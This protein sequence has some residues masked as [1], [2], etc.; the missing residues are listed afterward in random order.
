MSEPEPIWEGP[1]H[2]KATCPKC[3]E[4]RNGGE[5]ENPR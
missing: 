2:Y 1:G 3:G 4:E 5:H